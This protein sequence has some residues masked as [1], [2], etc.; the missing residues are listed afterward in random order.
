[1]DTEGNIYHSTLNFAGNDNGMTANS[2]QFHSK[3][4][5]HFTS[6]ADGMSIGHII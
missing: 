6:H 1:M 3:E 4:T 2:C 5:K